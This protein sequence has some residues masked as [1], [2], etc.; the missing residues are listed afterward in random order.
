[1]ARSLILMRLYNRN[2]IIITCPFPNPVAQE[3]RQYMSLEC[4]PLF[5]IANLPCGM[6]RVRW[7]D[8]VLMAH[9]LTGGKNGD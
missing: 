1:M 3:A 8:V 2:F 6:Q 4:G 9:V 7:S 5:V